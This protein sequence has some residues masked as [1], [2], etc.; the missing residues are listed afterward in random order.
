MLP[1]GVALSSGYVIDAEKEGIFKFKKI[2][3]KNQKKK[4]KKN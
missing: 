1:Y 4:S 2:H 3:R